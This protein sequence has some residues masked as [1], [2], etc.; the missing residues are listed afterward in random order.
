MLPKDQVEEA[1][2]RLQ[3]SHDFA[4]YVQDIKALGVIKFVFHVAE[5][6]TIF[7]GKHGDMHTTAALYND[8]YV[9]DMAASASRM[10]VKPVLHQFMRGQVPFITFCQQMADAGVARWV[11]NTRTMQAVYFNAGNYEVWSERV[12][13]K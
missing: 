5:G 13:G 12:A 4:Q 11:T 2:A 7:H 8:M 6:A 10:A 9:M 3:T 1:Y